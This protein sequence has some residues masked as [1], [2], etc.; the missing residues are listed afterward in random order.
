MILEPEQ[1]VPLGLKRLGHQYSRSVK[2]RDFVQATLQPLNNLEAVFFSL[3][4][5]D[6]DTADGALLDLLGRIVGAPAVIQ[7][8][9]AAP[10]FGFEGQINTLPFEEVDASIGG[11]WDDDTLQE[12]NFLSVEQY[13]KAVRVQILKNKSTCTPD[14][15]IEIIKMITDIPFAYIDGSM[16]IGIGLGSEGISPLDQNLITL[17]L[18]KPSG[19]QLRFIENWIGGFGWVDQP[20]AQGFGEEN[21]DLGGYWAVEL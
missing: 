4:N 18:P 17:F 6:L 19:V 7:G 14:E 13:R 5:I 9:S 11:Y 8:L 10:A 1:H 15:I 21:P 2:F 16:W 12:Q 20:D 3:L